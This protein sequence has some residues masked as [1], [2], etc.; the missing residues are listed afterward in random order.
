MMLAASASVRREFFMANF[1][2]SEWLH[3]TGI[4]LRLRTKLNPSYLL[5]E[6]NDGHIALSFEFRV[7]AILPDAFH[8]R[9]LLNSQMRFGRICISGIQAHPHHASL[10]IQFDRVKFPGVERQ[11]KSQ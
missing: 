5:A 10:L 7:H 11:P 3:R 4:P 2:P 6:R 9:R 8:L 1:S